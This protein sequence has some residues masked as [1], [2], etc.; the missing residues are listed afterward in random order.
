VQLLKD[1]SLLELNER[2]E[3]W[4]A[5]TILSLLSLDKL[6]VQL[7]ELATASSFLKYPD[8]ILDG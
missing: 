6:V 8:N 7:A 2:D 5:S 1:M 3:V 4:P